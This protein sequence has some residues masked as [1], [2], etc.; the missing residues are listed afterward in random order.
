[1]ADALSVDEAK[2]LIRLCETGRL[3]EVEAWIRAGKSLVVP[4]E[5]RKKPLSVAISTEFHSLVELL[6]RH[7]HRQEAKNDALRQAL[8]LDRPAFV[9]LAVAHGADIASIPFLDV[10]MTGDR[11]VVASFL[12]KGADPIANSKGSVSGQL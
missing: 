2:H 6:I 9:E 5:I 11:T 1:M 12:E 7:E 8:F 10:L 3:Y 4:G